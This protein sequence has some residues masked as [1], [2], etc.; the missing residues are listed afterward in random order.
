MKFLVGTDYRHR[1]S[2]SAAIYLQFQF[3]K[4]TR[5]LKQPTRDVVLI[6]NHLFVTEYGLLVYC[7]NEARPSAW[8]ITGMLG[9]SPTQPLV[10]GSLLRFFFIKSVLHRKHMSSDRLGH[11]RL[12][13]A[14]PDIIVIFSQSG[15][16]IKS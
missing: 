15:F 3:T 2:E 6:G 11:S 8:Y 1:L 14:T 12:S 4:K 7:F 10:G 9:D 13:M 5:L 16:Y